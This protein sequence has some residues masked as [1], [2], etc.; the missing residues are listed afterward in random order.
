MDE[1]DSRYDVKGIEIEFKRAEDDVEAMF[2]EY[3]NGVELLS[4]EAK[5]HTNLPK[6]ES[7]NFDTDD[8]SLDLNH[9]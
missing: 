9:E 8:D 3:M 5:S 2:Q 6:L 1:M 7:V 4:E